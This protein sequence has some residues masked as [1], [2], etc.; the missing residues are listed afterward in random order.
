MDP[1][2]IIK[3]LPE[4]VEEICHGSP[5]ILQGQQKKRLVLIG[6]TEEDRILT[7]V[8]EPKGHGAYYPITAYASDSQ[9][10]NVYKRLQGGKK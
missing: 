4:E 1:L 5:V 7:I 10:I 9:D 3:N 6:S 2:D 8:L